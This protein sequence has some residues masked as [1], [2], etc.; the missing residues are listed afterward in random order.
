MQKQLNDLQKPIE[1]DPDCNDGEGLEDE[2]E[3]RDGRLPASNQEAQ[4]T[5]VCMCLSIYIILCCTLPFYVQNSNDSVT[6]N[7]PVETGETPAAAKL[8]PKP[9]AEEERVTVAQEEEE[10]EDLFK[11][12]QDLFD[13]SQI[14]IC[15]KKIQEK[16]NE[17]HGLRMVC[18]I[19]N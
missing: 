8:T 5:K 15:L 2:E 11:D 18:M 9:V 1:D 6:E 19:F 7:V 16:E 4:L 10:E 14:K 12:D 13:H 3:N 17:L